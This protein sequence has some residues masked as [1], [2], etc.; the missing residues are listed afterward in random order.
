[1]TYGNIARLIGK[2]RMSRQVGWALHKNPD[3]DN[4]PCYRV[5]DRHGSPS[6]AFA[7]GGENRQI[8]LLKNEGVE[9]EKEKVK[10][11]YFTY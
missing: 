11:T 8:E 10:K 7:F 5:V 9:F 3:P 6:K 4:I 2:S 1:M